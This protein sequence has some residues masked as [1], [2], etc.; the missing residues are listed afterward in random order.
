[1]ALLRPG[2]TAVMF[3]GLPGGTEVPFD[4]T[5]LHYAGLTIR[6]AFHHAPRHVR[7]ALALLAADPEPFRP[8]LTHR[9]GLDE[10]ATPLAMTCGL[11][12]RDGL[13]KAVI[14]P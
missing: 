2:G 9:Y 14:E 5:R 8:L 4:A 6:G 10:V 1:V 11:L 12:P 13:L 7:D 3:G